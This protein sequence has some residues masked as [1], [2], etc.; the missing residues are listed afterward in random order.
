MFGYSIPLLAGRLFGLPLFV[1]GLVFLWNYR[2]IDEPKAMLRKSLKNPLVW[3]FLMLAWLAF[4]YEVVYL[5][6]QGA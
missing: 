2:K 5:A 6:G 1:L 3:F 4:A